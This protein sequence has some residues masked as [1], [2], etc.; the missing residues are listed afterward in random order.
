M[1]KNYSKIINLIERSRSKNNV[2]WMDLLKIAIRA[3]PKKT[4]KVLKKI[5]LSDKKISNLFKKLTS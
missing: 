4:I 3:E 2:N 1:A 5:N